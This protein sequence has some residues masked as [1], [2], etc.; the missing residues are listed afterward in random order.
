MRGRGTGGVLTRGRGTG[1]GA[2]EE[3]HRRRDTGGGAQ[4]EARQSRSEEERTGR[5]KEERED[6]DEGGGM[7]G[8]RKAVSL[9]QSIQFAHNTE[10][11][12]TDTVGVDQAILK[13]AHTPGAECFDYM[14]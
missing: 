2:Q 5:R 13:A 8:E 3:G 4:G 14:Q 9:N 1:G 7:D 6:K 11:Y 12:C 10:Y